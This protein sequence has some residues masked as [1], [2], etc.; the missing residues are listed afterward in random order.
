MG[1]I[2]GGVL[3]G[4]ASGLL[5]GIFGQKASDSASKRQAN[6]M[7]E[8]TAMQVEENRRQ[9]DKMLELTQPQRDMFGPA[10]QYLQHNAAQ[11]H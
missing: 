5:G 8:S 6:A 9:F 4:V 3:G 10:G 1:P 11:G 7:A 2:L